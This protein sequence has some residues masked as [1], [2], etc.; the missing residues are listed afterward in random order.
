MRKWFTRKRVIW[1]SLAT[2][3]ALLLIDGFVARP[4][5]EVTT[6]GAMSL[7]TTAVPTNVTYYSYPL[8][9]SQSIEDVRC[10]LWRARNGDTPPCT[11]DAASAYL[12]SAVQSPNTLYLLWV[13]CV[14]WH[15]AGDI[16]KWQGYNVEFLPS[17]RKLIIHCYVAEPWI[18]FHQ[19]VF[20]VAALI[21]ATLLLVATDSMGSGPI[22]IVEDDRQEHLVG[23]RSI[24]SPLGSA[25]IS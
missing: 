23:D 14:D 13:G 7:K 11:P 19:R 21:P 6:P 1:L 2:I 22:Q 17:G 4:A 3:V 8:P 20:G 25:V 16:I 15:G 5:H 18:T 24:E 9:A 12:P 10:H